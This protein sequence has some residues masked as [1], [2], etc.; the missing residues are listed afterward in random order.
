[1][2]KN[3]KFYITTAIDYVNADPHIGHAYQKIIADVL[4]RWHKLKG[5]DVFFLTGTDEHG[6]K[7]VRSAEEKGKSLK[8]FVDEMSE[9]FKE[10]WKALHIEYDRFI[11]TTDKDHEKFVQK[12]VKKIK[13]DIYKGEYEGFYCVG[14]EAYITE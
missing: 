5:K 10:A 3:N 4:A 6:Q 2:A 12:F 1:M 14:C 13:K 8:E 11:R 7:L 9:K